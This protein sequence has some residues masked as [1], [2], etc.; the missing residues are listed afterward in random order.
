[1]NLSAAELETKSTN[2]LS[3]VFIVLGGLSL[4]FCLYALVTGFPPEIF[5]HTLPVKIKNMKKPLL[6]AVFFF[7]AAVLAR[8]SRKEA[9]LALKSRFEGLSAYPAA[10]WAI[11]AFHA[12]L[13]LWIQINEYLA[14]DINFIPFFFYDYQLYYAMKGDFYYT[15]LLH[16]HYHINNILI[17]LAPLWSLFK[18]PLFLISLHGIIAALAA[19]PLYL[20]ARDQLK[21]AAAGIVIILAYLGSSYMNG[22]QRVNFCVEIFYPVLIFWAFYAAL[23]SRWI[24]YSI[25]AALILSV[26]DDSFAYLGALGIALFF[27]RGKKL[28]GVLSLAAGAV[29][30]ILLN[31]FAMP[32]SDEVM[33]SLV[34]NYVKYGNSVSE[35][36]LYF[37]THPYEIVVIFLNHPAKLETLFNILYRHGFFPLFTP[38]SFALLFSL[39]PLFLNSEGRTDF[40]L[41]HFHYAGPVLPFIYISAISGFSFVLKRIPEKRKEAFLWAALAVLFVINA[42]HFQTR[43]ITPDNL[44]SIKWAKSL[45][46]GAN[47]VTHGSLMPYIGY[48]EYN[49]FF[50]APWENPKHK[51]HEIYMN[52][53]YYLIDY[54]VNHYPMNAGFFG[55]KVAALSAN[56]SYRLAR[57]DDKR[58]LFERVSGK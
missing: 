51:H 30:F 9:A 52:A 43:K 7:A 21:S 39:I 38:A 16:G 36:A 42:G 23:K 53:D 19:P 24:L 11:T 6:A 46:E 12:L 20:I 15:A 22:L 33:E 14:V 5:G 10:V 27:M 25:F 8:S 56:P 4:V 2:V 18:S 45:P 40:Y 17:P 49:Y 31:S 37:L 13:F 50:A 48:K 3:R 58:F 57:H 35:I 1:M 54:T 32:G 47:V 26:K 44:E 55:E 29:F 41:L 28:A 34:W